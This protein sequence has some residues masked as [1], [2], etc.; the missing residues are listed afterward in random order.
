MT[1]FLAVIAV[2]WATLFGYVKLVYLDQNIVRNLALGRRVFRTA[3]QVYGYAGERIAVRTAIATHTG[4]FP[5]VKNV[6]M[7]F[8]RANLNGNIELRGG[9]TAQQLHRAGWVFGNNCAY[10]II[11]AKSYATKVEHGRYLIDKKKAYGFPRPK[12]LVLFHVK[13]ANFTGNVS[14]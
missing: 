2:F 8:V 10:D 1:D 3:D 12:N 4:L 13:P 11:S 6:D 14:S 7:G 5:W 9:L